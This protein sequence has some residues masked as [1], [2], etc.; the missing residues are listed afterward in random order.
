MTLDELR[1]LT[2]HY[3]YPFEEVKLAVKCFPEDSLE[4]ALRAGR[5]MGLGNVLFIYLGF[6]HD[7]IRDTS[8]V[9]KHKYTLRDDKL[10]RKD[11][12]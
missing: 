4:N 2:S 10:V 1:E 7:E 8:L 9:P 3:S 5:L 11:S 6:S 12:E